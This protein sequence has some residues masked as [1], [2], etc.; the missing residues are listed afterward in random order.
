MRKRAVVQNSKAQTP[1]RPTTEVNGGPLTNTLQVKSEGARSLE[2]SGKL[3][4]FGDTVE[5]HMAGSRYTR[6]L[7]APPADSAQGQIS[8]NA[9]VGRALLGKREGEVF[10]VSV[11]E[12]VLSVELLAIRRN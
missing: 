9:A 5:F 1:A 2:S 8:I 4:S 10:T 6:K 3:V 7:V 11:P 12:G